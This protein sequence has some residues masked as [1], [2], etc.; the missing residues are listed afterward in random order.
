[1]ERG[2][3]NDRIT[4]ACA[5]ILVA[6]DV[7]SWSIAFARH[8]VAN[9]MQSCLSRI[10]FKLAI[11][12]STSLNLVQAVVAPLPTAAEHNLSE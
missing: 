3:S 8:A 9:D 5:S 10:Q 6:G 4:T 12:D 7:C 2:G 1:M 11:K